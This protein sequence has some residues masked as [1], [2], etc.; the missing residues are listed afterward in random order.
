MGFVVQMIPAL[1]LIILQV[2]CVQGK[3]SFF[4]VLSTVVMF[5]HS[6]HL[7]TTRTFQLL[8]MCLCFILLLYQFA[9]IPSC[10]TKIAKLVFQRD[11]LVDRDMY[12]VF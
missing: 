10:N 7:E 1:F 6:V 5:I 9:T 12:T 3:Y 4:L 2:D 11:K 8:D